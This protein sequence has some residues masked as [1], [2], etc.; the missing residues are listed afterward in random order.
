M[1]LT[2]FGI[3]ECQRIG[4]GTTFAKKREGQR[5]CSTLCRNAATK[6]RARG[7]KSGDITAP[8]P[9]CQRSGDTAPAP[10]PRAPDAP[11]QPSYDFG[12]AGDPALQGDDYPLDYYPDGY[13][14]L[15]T[16]LRRKAVR[17]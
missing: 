12:K 11:L 3:I 15:P 2:H 10:A 7:P 14:V 6:A 1:T 17:P 4:C 16:C 5:Y 9:S 13:P 8:A